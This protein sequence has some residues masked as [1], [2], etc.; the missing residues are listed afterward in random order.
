M[1]KVRIIQLAKEWGVDVDELISLANDKLSDKMLTGKLRATWISEEGQKILKDAT[2]IPECVPKHYEG[3]VIKP[4]ANPNYVY[5][6]IKE[7]DKKVPVIVPRRWRG[8]LR[9]KNVL[10][11]AIQDVNGTSYRYRER[12]H[13]K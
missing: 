8:R 11:E 2:S 12:H 5:A 4:A 7:I 6:F 10:I 9:G 1:A 13:V 3:R